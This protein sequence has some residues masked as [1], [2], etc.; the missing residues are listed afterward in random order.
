LT[1]FEFT[2]E[3]PRENTWLV[4]FN[5]IEV[6]TTS[7]DV[8]MGV[9]MIPTADISMPPDKELYR[10][11]AEDR[12]QVS[13]FYLDNY[14]T[15]LT[16]KAPDFRLLYEGDII[17]WQ[18]T[19][20]PAGRL[21]RF[22]VTNYLDIL[23]S[24]YTFFMSSVDNLTV[25]TLDGKVN[26]NQM[27]SFTYA[28][29]F[30]A[31]LLFRGLD[32]TQGNIRRPYDILNNVI[33]ACIDGQ[34][35]EKFASV[36]AVNFYCRYMKRTM[37]EQ[38]TAPSPLLEI[39]HM[40]IKDDKDP[41]AIFPLLRY[42]QFSDCLQTISKRMCEVADNSVWNIVRDLFVRM[43]YEITAITTAPIAQMN[44]GKGGVDGEIL[45][46]PKFFVKDGKPVPEDIQQP[47]R[48]LNYITKPEWKFGIPPMCNVIFPSMITQF[49]MEED[50]AAQATRLHLR[51]DVVPTI[52]GTPASAL[53]RFV[54]TGVAYPVRAQEELEKRESPVSGQGNP[55]V[56]G[57]NFLIWPEEFFR[58]PNVI[59]EKMPEWFLYLL[60]SS[61]RPLRYDQI[62]PTVDDTTYQRDIYEW[63]VADKD[64]T[65]RKGATDSV[66]KQLDSVFKNYD[67][68]GDTETKRATI[69]VK[70]N[71]LKRL[72]ARHEYHRQRASCKSGAVRTIFDPYLVP[73][74]P[75]VVF[76]ESGTGNHCIGY[77]SAVSHSLNQQQ[78]GTSVT[79][80]HLQTLDEYMQGIRESRGGEN[81]EAR[82][83]T[84]L[85]N[86]PYPV[87]DIRII[88][89]MWEMANQYFSDLFHQHQKYDSRPLKTL[90]FDFTKAIELVLPSGEVVSAEDAI[91]YTKSSLP[92]STYVR[93][94]PTTAFKAMFENATD[95]MA[96]I[97]RP[98]CTLEEY[99]NFNGERGARTGKILPNDARQG[100]GAV[101]YE[102]IF[103]VLQ[104]PGTQP[105]FNVDNTLANPVKEE[106][107]RDWETRL[108]N[109]RKKVIFQL[110]PQE[111]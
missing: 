110:H 97:S 29:V 2:K 67:E 14:H 33:R 81:P 18:Y 56:S 27:T 75:V 69:A 4:Y 7:I 62:K 74:F 89:Q 20:T 77:A 93:V 65:L 66:V 106:T 5:G 92:L 15:E 96:L 58:G 41:D 42:A 13:A 43:Y 59:Q 78:T 90:A 94:Q 1:S 22:R 52:L 86:P 38:R 111:E 45:G 91:D 72:Y 37:F 103:N 31:S 10:L 28:P 12:V 40:R 34:A 6:P 48:I 24:L 57:K 49:A 79:L 63:K 30:P 104:G 23:D 71:W 70:F 88:E 83:Y 108:M 76:D 98:I 82:I 54:E 26:P 61:M 60:N 87:P 95:A 101:Y 84:I 35:H 17:G 19:N 107:R 44:I 68:T 9:W 16:G 99:I 47:N 64:G 73:G 46:P 50:Y 109:Y 8:N 102:K 80:T 21:L 53:R 39:D 55:N 51:D 32:Q 105:V 100:K 11:G 36:A 3:T 85:A 25:A